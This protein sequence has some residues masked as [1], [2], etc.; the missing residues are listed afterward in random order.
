M[1]KKFSRRQLLKVLAAAAGGVGLGKVLG[2]P[3]L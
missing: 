1:T 3:L 2:A